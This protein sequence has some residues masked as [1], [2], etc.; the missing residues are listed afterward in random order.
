MSYEDYGKIEPGTY[1]TPEDKNVIGTQA[2]QQV[3][4]NPTASYDNAEPDQE[5]W[6]VVKE[7][8]LDGIN[9]I[10]T[11]L[12][13]A[14]NVT[15]T[16]IEAAL[17]DQN[18]MTA[19][20]Q[21]AQLKRRTYA[22][23]LRKAVA[24]KYGDSW[25]TRDFSQKEGEFDLGDIPD[26]VRDVTIDMAHDP[27]F[28]FGAGASLLKRGFVKATEKTLT[29]NLHKDIQDEATAHAV[30]QAV[31]KGHK[32]SDIKWKDPSKAREYLLNQQVLSDAELI[33]RGQDALS[34][35]AMA[36]QPVATA[37]S[38][39]MGGVYGVG[40][41]AQAL[42]HDETMS[43]S[44]AA[45][46]FAMGAAAGTVGMRVAGNKLKGG[47]AW[48]GEKID[49]M[50]APTAE[51]KQQ[52]FDGVGRMVGNIADKTPIIQKL[53]IAIK[54]TKEAEKMSAILGRKYISPLKAMANYG[55]TKA[56]KEASLMA[57]GNAKRLEVALRDRFVNY[58]K[59]AW[60]H[61]VKKL[62]Q[63]QKSE[64]GVAEDV[65][66]ANAPRAAQPLK[67]KV[68]ELAHK[69]IYDETGQV[70]KE[71]L[72]EI[73]KVDEIDTS[74]RVLSNFEALQAEYRKAFGVEKKFQREQLLDPESLETMKYRREGYETAKDTKDMFEEAA[75]PI[76][77]MAYDSEIDGLMQMTYQNKGLGVW[78][79]IKNERGIATAK[80]AADE[81]PSKIMTRQFK[82]A[83]T[84]ARQGKRD[85]VGKDVDVP[86]K[87]IQDAQRIVDAHETASLIAARSKARG[88][89]NVIQQE[90]LQLHGTVQSQMKMWQR[91]AMSANQAVKK[92][93][94]L[95]GLSW[96]K[97]NL[98]SNMRQ[99]AVNSGMMGLLDS[100][101][102]VS[103]NNAVANDVRKLFLH[104]QK[105]TPIF[106]FQSELTEDAIR[107]GVM[108]SPHYYD[109][110]YMIE[111]QGK[112]L[113][114]EE[115]L[116][117]IK[118]SK[119]HKG[120]KALEAIHDS[121]DMV[122][123]RL[124]HTR[125][126][127]NW[128]EA[129]ARMNT[130]KRTVD[131]LNKN[132]G[133]DLADAVGKDAA[134][135]AIMRQALDVTNEVFFDYSKLAYWERNVAREFIPFYSF[136]KQNM[137]YQMKA[138]MQ[139]GRSA[140]LGALARTTDGRYFGSEPLT[141]EQ[142]KEAPEYLQTKN[143]FKWYN[144]YGEP[145]W[146]YSTSDAFQ[147]ATEMM[148][149]T[150]FGKQ[151]LSNLNPILSTIIQQA[152]GQN[153]F[154]GTPLDPDEIGGRTEN[155]LA[156]LFSRGY[157]IGH[158]YN[159]I[160]HVMDKTEAM[161]VEEGQYPQG[162][163]KYPVFQTLKSQPVTDRE[164]VTRT[165][166]VTSWA[167]AGYIGWLTQIG[168]QIQKYRAG[169]Q[170]MLGLISNLAGPIQITQSIAEVDKRGIERVEK[171]RIEEQERETF[172]AKRRAVG[173]PLDL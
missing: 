149:V 49:K 137:A 165:D 154:T 99:A 68:N 72:D 129:V 23:D 139:P 159:L 138:M 106:E 30:K 20:G 31:A 148:S 3:T 100:V 141:S 135:E 95:G 101:Q 113:Y 163:P 4:G 127:G 112:F 132:M 73:E 96:I 105:T 162:D 120:M 157:T 55:K 160:Q 131:T 86:I 74:I 147:A 93:L 18:V 134:K 80:I 168:G 133:K 136:Y 15:A 19:M 2:V 29:K 121:L 111:M 90:A 173:K 115:V 26:F 104:R 5:T 61:E 103:W 98:W 84:A 46:A 110:D 13:Y 48:M 17:R 39:V 78:S 171:Q 10:F 66:Y 140:R 16:G 83:E 161:F 38:G 7:A 122:H 67:D 37:W 169:K 64:M 145:Q 9:W 166:M 8:T 82:A 76:P 52:L 62:T 117:K 1:L 24:D 116:A 41:Q 28:I 167:A 12:D 153:W 88:A 69:K 33:K 151:F 158:F 156:Y 155:Q 87:N 79:P 60:Q 59:A 32:V 109:H 114:D 21:A 85:F 152:T 58:R 50:V 34:G 118:E 75:S 150:G 47:A 124:L 107:L 44:D 97:N 57:A 94:L 22:H 126:V 14:R 164:W 51:V 142:A 11:G 42:E 92:G 119:N 71:L 91:M 123:S 143:A 146:I 125:Q 36:G 130:W 53:N 43:L 89:L 70:R 108:D 27:L 63:K 56:E 65:F 128:I 25:L 40:A 144:K 77:K 6:G 170:D 102:L 45:K 35:A 54:A 81:A 172:R